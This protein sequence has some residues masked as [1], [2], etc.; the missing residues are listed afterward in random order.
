MIPDAAAR[1]TSVS[2]ARVTGR[3]AV[4]GFAR[5]PPPGAASACSASLAWCGADFGARP[6]CAGSGGLTHDWQAGV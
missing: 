2:G 6:A 1:V 5:R 3:A 4:S